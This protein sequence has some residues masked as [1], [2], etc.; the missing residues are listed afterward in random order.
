MLGNKGVPY[1]SDYREK[2][3]TWNDGYVSDVVYPA[4][5]NAQQS[6]AHLSFASLLAGCEPVALDKPFTY[7]ELGCGQGLTSNV[8]AATH[9]HAR[10]FASDF[11]PAHIAGARELA[12][13]AGLDNMVF[14]EES[15]EDLAAGKIAD[16]PQF[17]FITMYGVYSWISDENR[18]HIVR[19]L[20]RYLKPGGIV[21]LNYNAMPGWSAASAL[22]RLARLHADFH[23]DG[24]AAQVDQARGFVQRLRNTGARFFTANASLEPFL[25]RFASSDENYRA[26]EYLNHQTSALYHADVARELAEAKLD[27][28]GSAH[29]YLNFPELHL[30]PEQQQFIATIAHGPLRETARDCI[31]NPSMRQ[32]IF[33]RG[34]R[35]LSPARLEAWL[36]RTGL[37]L[38]R[39]NLSGTARLEALNDDDGKLN[40]L[41]MSVQ[42]ALAKRPHRLSEL[43]ALPAFAQQPVSALLKV[44]AL[45]MQF[46]WAAP[47]FVQK[48]AI[49]PAPAQRLNM[50]LARLAETG[51]EHEVLA[52]PL[53]GSGTMTGLMQYLVYPFAAR[54]GKQADGELIARHVASVLEAQNIPLNRDGA[55]IECAQARHEEI[56]RTVRAILELR[57]PLWEQHDAL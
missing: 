56:L 41:Y 54:M 33:V 11:N 48:A 44:A 42:E 30:T 12:D 24:S 5:F 21:Y 29:A 23:P 49:D 53:L 26:H 35:S 57:V 14:L 45:L 20:K 37:A 9:P 50:E 28:A 7:F 36:S 18:R 8:L 19:F 31:L 22:K 1:P 13:A 43:A 3:M 15:F 39:P 17:D 6:P 27:Y 16:L 10:F 51:S 55:L 47:Y 38:A 2:N 46:E 34:V 4:T 40:E 25:E 52:S 32:D